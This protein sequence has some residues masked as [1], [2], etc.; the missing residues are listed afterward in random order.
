MTK[1]TTIMMERA[2]EDSPLH[3]IY[4]DDRGTPGVETIGRAL[5]TV[6]DGELM[7][8]FR[9]GLTGWHA[10]FRAASREAAI[11]YISEGYNPGLH[12]YDPTILVTVGGVHTLAAEQGG[13]DA[14]RTARD[15]ITATLTG[16][17]GSVSRGQLD[18][19]LAAR[20]DLAVGA[21][22]FALRSMIDDAT[23]LTEG[24]G[25]GQLLWLAPDTPDTPDAPGLGAERVAAIAGAQDAIAD[26]LMDEGGSATVGRIHDALAAAET[27]Q[28]ED[29]DA[30][31]E[32][33]VDQGC[34]ER[35]GEGLGAVVALTSRATYRPWATA[36]AAA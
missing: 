4:A 36:A 21:P 26:A 17:A 31:L 34:A 6:A 32:A 14:L 5:E 19:I 10:T 3:H 30:A 20:G 11:R 33:L 28:A 24:E 22:Q 9:S 2:G 7:V 18:D 13:P 1:R 12:D 15:A 27:V 8:S 35:E 16:A 25:P 29:A 23:V